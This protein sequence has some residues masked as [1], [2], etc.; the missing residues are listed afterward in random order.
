EAIPPEAAR[1]P[2][3]PRPLEPCCWLAM[4]QWTLSPTS[5]RNL[6]RLQIYT[7]SGFAVEPRS[8]VVCGQV[9]AG[10]LFKTPPLPPMAGPQTKAAPF[11]GTT[12]LWAKD[13]F[14]VADMT[15]KTSGV[16]YR[17]GRRIRIAHGKFRGRSTS[18]RTVLLSPPQRFECRPAEGQPDDTSCESGENVAKKMCA[19]IDSR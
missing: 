3:R 16:P 18:F 2:C 1:N 11:Y 6:S 8:I 19:K 15:K 14:V 9:T 17:I 5:K 13:G 10:I 12:K 4:E 7:V